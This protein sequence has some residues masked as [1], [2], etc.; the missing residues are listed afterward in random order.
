M[1]IPLETATHEI[2]TALKQATQGLVERD[3]MAE[4]IVLGAV[5]SEHVLAI[6]SPGTAKSAVVRRVANALGGQYFEYLLGRYTEPSELFGSVDLN[7]LRDGRV[8]TLTTGM[9]PEADIVFL[10]EVFLGS[11]AVLNTL[12]GVL[13]ERQFRRGHTSI[14][15][16]LRICVGASNALPEDESLAA[17]ADRF[18]VHIFVEPVPDTLLDDLLRGGWGL[19]ENVLH[20]A[21]G[22]EHLDRLSQAAKAADMSQC[23]PLIAHCIRLLRHA[24]IH[25]SD[26]RI[27]KIQKLVSAAAILSGRT[28]PNSADL[29]PIIY[30]IPTQAGQAL[31]RDILQDVLEQSENKTLLISAEE[32][33]ASAA[34]RVARLIEQI[35][36]A[37][38]NNESDSL[39]LEAIA[40]E[41]D[42]NFSAETLPATLKVK[43]DILLTLLNPNA[44]Q[45]T[46]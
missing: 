11:T 1:T 35:D 25:L 6:G 20:S 3:L 31:A 14:T 43:R 5:A 21:Q 28:T 7:K 39:Q 17:F 15:C 33:A 27:V 9:L 12:L 26:R 18:L 16:P 38:L 46:E 23:Q 44:S 42:A 2:R 10:D 34:S 24:N 19:A 40:R 36:Q 41:I 13:N 30:A 32:A 29:W 45:V 22:L 4:M 8:E 37:V